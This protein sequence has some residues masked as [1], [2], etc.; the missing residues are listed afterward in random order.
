ML[1]DKLRRLIHSRYRVSFSKSGE[2]IQIFKLLNSSGGAYLDIG[3]F[4]P[5]TFSN[6]Y[7]F[8]LRGWSGVVVDPNPTLKNLFKTLRPQDSFVNKGISSSPGVLKYYTLPYKMSSMNTFDYS[9]LEKNNLV[10]YIEKELSI[11]IITMDELIS[12]HKLENK[13]DFLDVDVEGLDLDV[14]KS[15]NW[16][17]FRPKV[18]MVETDQ[19]FEEDLNSCIYQLLREKEYRLISK[20]VQNIH[21]SGNLIFVKNEYRI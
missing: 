10:Q 21:G 7:F 18:I 13:I 9:F 6:T 20:H 8:Y 1:K 19:S 3:C 11:P 12:E 4:E 2:D 15:N 17:L 16:E 5:V 14:L